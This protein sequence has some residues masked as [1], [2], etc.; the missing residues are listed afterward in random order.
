MRDLKNSRR[1]LARP[2]AL[3]TLVVVLLPLRTSAAEM[4]K[5]LAT[6]SA[7]TGDLA[8]LECFDNLSK[9]LGLSGPTKTNKPIKG[10]GKWDVS[11]EK[12]PIDDSK[13]IAVSIDASSGKSKWMK[14]VTLVLRC[15]SKKTEVYISW[16]EFLGSDSISVLTRMG[17]SPAVTSEW[18]LS[19]DKTASFHPGDNVA[20]I[21]DLVKVKKFAAQV[22]PY[23]SNP[24]TALFDVTGAENATKPLFE[25]CSTQSDQH[26]DPYFDSPEKGKN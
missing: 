15:M 20:F 13:T 6:C 5:S 22:T 24:I 8:R 9:G 2:G 1:L 7:I 21:N 12:N 3:A 14:P 4:K 11:I 17:D 25:T 10:K 18:N 26:A 19:S 23:D 16:G